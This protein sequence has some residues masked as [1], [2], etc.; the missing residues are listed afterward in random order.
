[1]LLID[2]SSSLT[3]KKFIA[4]LKS[5]W[6]NR[7]S[8]T[9]RFSF[10]TTISILFSIILLL[11]TFSSV[12]FKVTCTEFVYHEANSVISLRINALSS[13]F[14]VYN[15]EILGGSRTEYSSPSNTVITSES[16][17]K[18]GLIPIPPATNKILFFS[19]LLSQQKLPPDWTDTT[20]P[21]LH[22]LHSHDVGGWFVF[23]TAKSKYGN[24]PVVE[25][26]ENPPTVFLDGINISIHCPGIKLKLLFFLWCF[27]V[28]KVNWYKSLPTFVLLTHSATCI[29]E[30]SG[31]FS[32]LKIWDSF[33]LLI[34]KKLFE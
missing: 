5:K 2:S 31:I 3:F 25:V 21:T 18:S 9:V 19:K 4:F 33:S 32:T 23:W 12:N 11:S 24:C 6:F 14:T 15:K 1:M 22:S 28:R 30:S 8:S 34:S 13:D 17:L 16:I 27:P 10:F 29:F 7:F 26:M 20:S